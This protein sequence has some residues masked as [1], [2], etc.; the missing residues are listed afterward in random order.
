MF[1]FSL[2][3]RRPP[4]STRTDTLFPYTTLF[5]SARRDG[6]R[7]NLPQFDAQCCRSVSA[8][9]GAVTRR[10]S[11]AVCRAGAVELPEFR[12]GLLARLIGAPGVSA[13]TIDEA[14]CVS[15]WGHDFRPEYRQLGRLRSEE[16]TSE[17]QSLMRISSA[18]FCLKTKK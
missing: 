8:R 12:D 4:R 7:R 11:F 9:R 17:L 15:E 6:R 13:I 1:I 10:L 2:M 18:V 3:I 16:H 5:R 14:H